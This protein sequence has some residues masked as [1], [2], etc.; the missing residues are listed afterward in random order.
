MVCNNIFYSPNDCDNIT[1]DSYYQ[2][3]ANLIPNNHAGFDVE[4]ISWTKPW[5]FEYPKNGKENEI[6]NQMKNRNKLMSESLTFAVNEQ[7]W[8]AAQK[9][10][11]AHGMKF[12]HL[13]DKDIR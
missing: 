12:M 11:E 6:V 13:L 4:L 8:K 3:M 7:K 9:F 2:E 10:A 1:L 5:L